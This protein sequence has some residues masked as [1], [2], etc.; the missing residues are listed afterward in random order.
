MKKSFLPVLLVLLILLVNCSDY[1]KEE[2]CGVSDPLKNINWL[3][4]IYLFAERNNVKSRIT[5]VIYKDEEGFIIETFIDQPA[6][7]MVTFR[8]C[9]N[10]IIC[11]WGGIG[12]IISCPDFQDYVTFS[13]IL[14]TNE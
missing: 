12:G 6:D 8:N 9:S 7:N 10:E 4:E 2:F 11:E 14:W 1:P 13:E 5:K 3:H